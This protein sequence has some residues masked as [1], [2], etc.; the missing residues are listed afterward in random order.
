MRKTMK[1]ALARLASR[2][3]VAG[4][5]TLIMPAVAGNAADAPVATVS[6]CLRP[7]QWTLLGGE[8]PRTGDADAV[9]A[10]ISARD[11][12]LL[13]EQH[14]EDDHHRW[15]AQTLAALHARRPEMLIGFEMFPRRVQPVLDRWVAGE[16]TI[17]Q[18]LDQSE[19]NAVWNMPADLYLPLF[20][21]AR[22]NRI[23]MVALNVDRKLT[24]AITEN[25]W[26]A[27]P[28]VEREGVGRAASPPDDYREYLRRVYREHLASRA[29]HGMATEQDDKGFGYFVESQTTWDRA[30]AE[31]I[32][33]A[34]ATDVNGKRPLVVGVMGSG[35][36]RFGH[37]VPHQ[38][39]ALGVTRIGT[40]LPV[41][42]DVDCTELTNG[43]ADA[44]FAMPDQVAAHPEPPRLG[45]RLEQDKEGVRIM[46]VTPGSL[47]EAT[48]L[49]D[50]DRIV[51]VAGV[52]MEK[53]STL[54]ASVRQQ[55]AGTWLP[56]RVGRDGETL[57]LVIKFPPGREV[58][59]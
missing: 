11:V 5:A 39:R 1:P 30:M 35:H 24:R 37:G 40:V 2:L 28:E 49:N 50:G 29:E 32:D 57:D 4:L 19:W 25:G 47:A 6:T 18:F 45:V 27:V 55:P 21:F 9:L 33:R 23:P 31:A 22:I 7:A 3:F 44:V 54:V 53:M 46:T 8:E 42:A 34:L 56:I 20:Q 14:D 16:L 48:G 59:K 41:R 10:A 12:V 36:I 17:K 52:A 58:R 26:D 51:E 38:L 43:L 13:G 15:Q